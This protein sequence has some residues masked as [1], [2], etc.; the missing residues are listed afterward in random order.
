MVF[1][2][3]R[4]RRRQAVRYPQLPDYSWLMWGVECF[5]VSDAALLFFQASTPTLR[6]LH[7]PTHYI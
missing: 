4:W 6:A 7:R 1:W 3:I 2:G 5:G